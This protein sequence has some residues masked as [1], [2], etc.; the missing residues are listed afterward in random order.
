MRSTQ[1]L[2]SDVRCRQ[3]AE[4]D[5]DGITDLL[6]RGFPYSRTSWASAFERLSRH[7]PPPGFPR[8]GYLLQ[9][10]GKPVGVILMIFSSIITNGE[11]KIRCSVSNWYVEPAFRSYAAL[12]SSYALK[13][14][15]VTYFVITPA[16]HVL[17]ILEAQGYSRYCS[18]RFAAVPALSAPS[19]GVRIEVVRPGLQPDEGLSAHEAE[20]LLTHAS[21][22]CISVVCHKGGQSYPFVF[23]TRRKYRV[24]P[25]ASLIYCRELEDVIQFA[26]NLGR[27]LAR[28]GFP[29]LTIDSNDAIDG[30][31]G[32]YSDNYPK[33][34]KGL[35]QPRIG[36]LAYSKRVFFGI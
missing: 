13:R 7:T 11:A 35:D 27:F 6:V 29:L 2:P 3:I 25:F 5:L 19:G 1:L 22:G 31:V 36:D 23:A 20:L 17:A 26:G 32:K 12:L 34:Y 21:Y 9:S 24:V 15:H 28:R 8:Y 30:L 33:Y 16:P 4:S 10:G 14:R 18:G